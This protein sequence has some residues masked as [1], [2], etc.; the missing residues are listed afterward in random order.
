MAN[1]SRLKNHILLNHDVLPA[2]TLGKSKRRPK[3]KGHF[4]LIHII[5]G[6]RH[7]QS[8]RR[9]RLHSNAWRDNITFFL[10][11]SH[12]RRFG[13]CC[14]ELSLV[15]LLLTFATA[16]LNFNSQL[17]SWIEN[18]SLP[19]KGWMQSPSTSAQYDKV[20]IQLK[21][22][23]RLQDVKPYNIGV[24]KLGLL[25]YWTLGFYWHSFRS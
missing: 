12:W 25:S 5:T 6:L 16:V 17:Y 13:V 4:K 22:K 7:R 19:S 2:Q 20:A 11:Q 9:P 3:S 8:A 18:E 15:V 23:F 1:K 21:L 24:G 10:A 14:V